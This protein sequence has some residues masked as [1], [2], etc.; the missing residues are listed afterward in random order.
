MPETRAVKFPTLQP[1]LHTSSSKYDPQPPFQWN[2]EWLRIHGLPIINE[3]L[4]PEFQKLIFIDSSIIEWSTCISILKFSLAQS[5]GHSPTLEHESTVLM[6][7]HGAHLKSRKKNFFLSRQ[8]NLIMT[9]LFIHL[10]FH[11]KV[12]PTNIYIV[13][14]SL[15]HRP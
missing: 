13:Y 3:E 5:Q 12:P 7:R 4:S 6:L 11:I 8:S 9:Y 1:N 10:F 2:L 14:E 15:I